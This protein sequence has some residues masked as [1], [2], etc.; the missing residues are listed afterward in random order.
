[1]KLMI[2]TTVLALSSVSM[3]TEIDRNHFEIVEIKMTKL[4]AS[5]KTTVLSARGEVGIGM[6]GGCE[7]TKVSSTKKPV[8]PQNL[9]PLDQ[10]EMIVDQVINIGKK[11]F[12]IVQAGKPVINVQTDVAT[13]LPMGARCWTDLQQWQMP[14][15][16]LYKMAFI[17][18]WGSE[19]V[20][21]S[22]RVLWLP[23]GTVDG[24]GQYIGYATMTPETIQVSWGF[25][26]HANV[27]IPTVFNMGTRA[28]PLAG[29]QM[30]MGYRIESPLT[31]VDQ[32][33]AFFVNGKGEFKQ[34][35]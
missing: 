5:S 30:T 26:L 33:Q 4:P 18:G 32:A 9:N 13:A 22:Y 6:V 34:L 14:Q 3:A 23:G 16:E 19:V 11:I 17:N 24:V 29:M 31:V 1:M 12:S 35:Q 15:S 27:S 7:C 21:M 2:L 10:V 28:A 20:T 25:G 8:D